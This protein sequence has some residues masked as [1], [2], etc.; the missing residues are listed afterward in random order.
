MTTQET[1]T[2]FQKYVIPNYTRY[3]VV[4]VKGAD[5]KR[6]PDFFTSQGVGTEIVE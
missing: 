3:P 4:L 6:Y 1:I 5:G 2:Q